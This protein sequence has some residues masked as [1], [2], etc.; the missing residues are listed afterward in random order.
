MLKNLD[1]IKSRIN[2]PVGP[3]EP[4]LGLGS[5]GAAFYVIEA[6]P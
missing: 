3:A 5:V 6:T 2:E 4:S 1:N